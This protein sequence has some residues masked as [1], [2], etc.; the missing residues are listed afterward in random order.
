[1]SDA[2]VT[3]IKTNEQAPADAVLVR[4]KSRARAV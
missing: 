2:N 3:L 4:N 1:M